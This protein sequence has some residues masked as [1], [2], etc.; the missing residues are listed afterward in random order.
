MFSFTGK[1]DDFFHSSHLI[2]LIRPFTATA[3]LDLYSRHVS[4][5]PQSFEY[6]CTSPVFCGERL[7]L[8]GK[9]D[10]NSGSFAV[11]AVNEM[12]SVVAKG[13]ITPSSPNQ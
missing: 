2:P 8:H 6:T 13:T 7:T 12:E 1:K 10:A 3:M 11:W 9:L 5:P 4:Q